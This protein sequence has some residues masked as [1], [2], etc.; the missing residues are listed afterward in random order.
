MT[1]IYHALMTAAMGRCLACIY[2]ITSLLMC[3]QE[4]ARPMISCFRY[5]LCARRFEHESYCTYPLAR[6]LAK[7]AGRSEYR[8][9]NILDS[10]GI[11]H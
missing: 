4:R 1:Y 3:K 5:F 7:S 6:V 9:E 11:A 10:R 2:N 8:R